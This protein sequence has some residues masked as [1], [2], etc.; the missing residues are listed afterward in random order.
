MKKDFSIID[1]SNSSLRPA[2]FFNIKP[3]SWVISKSYIMTITLNLN[4]MIRAEVNLRREYI[5]Q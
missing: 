1:L 2:Y 4:E 5:R 3:P